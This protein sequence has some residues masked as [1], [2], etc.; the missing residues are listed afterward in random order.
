V[1]G[2]DQTQLVPAYVEYEYIAH[3]IR[4]GKQSPHFRKVS[5]LSLLAQAIPLLKSRRALRMRSLRGHDPAM[6]NDVHGRSIS[7]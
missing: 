7:Q 3:L 4:T 6:G 1:Y 5:P 2:S